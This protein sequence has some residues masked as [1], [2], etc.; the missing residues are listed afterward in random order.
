M[1]KKEFAIEFGKTLKHLMK[2]KDFTQKNLAERAGLKQEQI[3]TYITGKVIPSFYIF[4]KSHLPVLFP[5]YNHPFILL[6][7]IGI[8]NSL[9]KC[10]IF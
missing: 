3:S 5:A 9:P 1:D 2:D 8:Y 6:Y 10:I 7:I 4:Y